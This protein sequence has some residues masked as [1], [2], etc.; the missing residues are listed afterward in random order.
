MGHSL[1]S[2]WCGTQGHQGM[3]THL[4]LVSS[5][6]GGEGELELSCTGRQAGLCTV[7]IIW[8]DGDSR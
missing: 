5:G 4:Q 3:W 2:G 6:K 1:T 7:S 8:L